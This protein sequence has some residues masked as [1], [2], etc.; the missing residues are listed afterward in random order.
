MHPVCCRHPPASVAIIVRRPLLVPDANSKDGSTLAI[1]YQLKDAAGRT[2]VDTTGLTVRPLLSYA[3]GVTPPTGTTA[4]N[5]VLP[6]CDLAGLGQSSGVGECTVEVAGRFFPA[7]GSLG[8]TVLLK[9]F[10]G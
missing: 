8:A 7:T 10:A 3:A 1:S 5:N 9:I 4:A 2:Q 6:D